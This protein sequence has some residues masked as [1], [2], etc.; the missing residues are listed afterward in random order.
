[1]PLI[2]LIEHG[3]IIYI[4]VYLMRNMDKIQIFHK[5]LFILFIHIPVYTYYII[6][7]AQP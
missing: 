6:D 7:S 2:C 3:L 4:D 5:I 1:M